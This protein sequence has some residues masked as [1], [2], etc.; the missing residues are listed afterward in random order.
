MRHSSDSK[1]ISRS[2]WKEIAK[3][4]QLTGIATIYSGAFSISLSKWLSKANA[5][6]ATEI[7]IA[8]CIIEFLTLKQQI[9]INQRHARTRSGTKHDITLLYF[10]AKS[11]FSSF[12]YMYLI[13]CTPVTSMQIL[14][15]I[16]WIRKPTESR[17]QARQPLSIVSTPRENKVIRMTKRITESC[18]IIGSMHLEYSRES[19]AYYI[20]K[21]EQIFKDPCFTVK[22]ATL[23]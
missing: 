21:K 23:I 1:Y 5:I 13:K 6:E 16:A 18:I 9:L 17:C 4:M 19:C 15:I 10:S 2:C 3:R 20:D 7:E 11:S 22:K 12:C 8:R 14:A